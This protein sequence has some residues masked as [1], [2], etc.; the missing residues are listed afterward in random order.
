M[1]ENACKRQSS[2]ENESET[3]RARLGAMVS[4]FLGEGRWGLGGWG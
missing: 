4:H 1:E 2:W 3:K